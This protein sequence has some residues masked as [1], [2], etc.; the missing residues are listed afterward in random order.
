MHKLLPISL[1]L[2]TLPIHAQVEEIHLRKLDDFRRQVVVDTVAKVLNYSDG[3]PDDGGNTAFWY[4]HNAKACVYRKAG[5][6]S[7]SANLRTITFDVV[8]NLRELSL[9]SFDRNSIK[10]QSY[11]FKY[12]LDVGWT[13]KVV[14]FADGRE[15]FSTAGIQPDRV[16]KGWSL[17]YSKYCVGAKKEF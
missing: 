11:D 17:I 5:Y 6:Q 3:L 7:T 2:A 12:P 10:Y 16:S 1:A 4:A 13:K 9:N 15:I 14:V 8:E